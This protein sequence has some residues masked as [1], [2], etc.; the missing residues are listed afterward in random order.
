MKT[1][2]FTLQSNK[3]YATIENVRKAVA[4]TGDQGFRHFIVKNEDG[5]YFP[6]FQANDSSA[7]AGVHFRWA[8]V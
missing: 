2:E 5:R 7:H 4:K 8:C 6:V 3:T 1:R